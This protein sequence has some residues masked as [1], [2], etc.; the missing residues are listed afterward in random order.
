M[1]LL[2]SPCIVYSPSSSLL[3]SPTLYTPRTMYIPSPCTLPLPLILYTPPHHVHSPLTMYTLPLPCTLPPHHVHSPL[4]MYTPPSPCKLLL[5]TYAIHLAHNIHPTHHVHPLSL[6]MSP[7]LW[8]AGEGN[9][10][11]ALKCSFL[12]LD[13]KLQE[14]LSVPITIYVLAC[15]LN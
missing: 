1:Y 13:R 8:P 10:S 6:T 9:Y 11:C 12:S 15:K 5:A 7:H 3:L 2:L 4:T 14:G